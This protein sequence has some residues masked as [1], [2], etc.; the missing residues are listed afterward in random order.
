MSQYCINKQ[1]KVSIHFTA[2]L[3]ATILNLK[4][5][6]KNN[7]FWDE[8]RRQNIFLKIFETKL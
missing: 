4:N 3:K 6:Q 7:F 8:K 2:K 5:V 1:K